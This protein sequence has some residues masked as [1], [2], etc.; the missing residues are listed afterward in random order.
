M[1]ITQVTET[2]N[3]TLTLDE[4]ANLEKKCAAHWERENTRLALENKKLT[5]LITT[6]C[7]RGFLSW[8]EI[9]EALK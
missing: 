6:A 5:E 2:E 3:I 4:Y 8:A 1:I 7:S 9:K